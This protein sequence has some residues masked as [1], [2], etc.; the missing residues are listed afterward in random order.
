M[1]RL[2]AQLAAGKNGNVE[3]EI[4]GKVSNENEVLFTEDIQFDIWTTDGNHEVCWQ[5]QDGYVIDIEEFHGANC[6][7]REWYE[8]IEILQTVYEKAL[9][10]QQENYKR[11]LDEELGR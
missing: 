11:I 5:L 9:P 7:P 3:Y 6:L 1:K 10:I 4:L 8:V 2:L